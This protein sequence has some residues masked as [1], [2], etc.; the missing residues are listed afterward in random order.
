M[1]HNVKI[2]I[3]TVAGEIRTEFDLYVWKL[4]GGFRC[5][6]IRR[7]PKLLYNTLY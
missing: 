6:S 3:Y 7:K 4:M 5:E 1:R 2:K